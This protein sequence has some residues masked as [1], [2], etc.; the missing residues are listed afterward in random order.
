[1]DDNY[2]VTFDSNVWETDTSKHTLQSMKEI[3]A[4]KLEK[5]LIKNQQVKVVKQYSLNQ[6][7]ELIRLCS[8]SFKSLLVQ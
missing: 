6:T 1:M 5:F 8:K 3:E 7:L 2:Y 4:S